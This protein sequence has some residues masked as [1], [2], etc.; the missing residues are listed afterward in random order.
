MHEIF[1]FFSRISGDFGQCSCLSTFPGF[2]SF[3]LYYVPVLHRPRLSFSVRVTAAFLYRPSPPFVPI[4]TILPL[5]LDKLHLH[6]RPRH[7]RRS[8][9]QGPYQRHPQLSD[10]RQQGRCWR[11]RHPE[12]VRVR[13]DD[14]VNAPVLVRSC[15]TRGNGR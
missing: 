9:Y 5:P 1:F 14:R 13:P 12:G 10:C 15:D 11:W 3:L 8:L 2:A 6:N 7:N 4:L